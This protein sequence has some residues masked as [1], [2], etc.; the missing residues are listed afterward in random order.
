MA[1]SSRPPGGETLA[2]AAAAVHH[3]VDVTVEKVA[4]VVDGVHDKVESARASIHEAKVQAAR[5][6]DDARQARDTTAEWIGA[7]RDAVREHPLAAF[8]G[9]LLLGAA[10]GSA[11]SSRR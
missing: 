7:A 11:A 5:L 4:P 3:A 2:H 10:L 9:A 1:A 8:A 6:R